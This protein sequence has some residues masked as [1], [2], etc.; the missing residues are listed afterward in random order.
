MKKILGLLVMIMI[1]A[2][3][4]CLDITMAMQQDME[5][6]STK[7]YERGDVVTLPPFGYS[8]AHYESLQDYNIGH[9]PLT[10]PEWWK[11]R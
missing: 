4:D 9:T 8:C 2:G 5:W 6:N 11:I 1:L 3:C 7:E 10:A